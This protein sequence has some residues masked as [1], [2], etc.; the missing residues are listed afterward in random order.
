MLFEFECPWCGQDFKRD[1]KFVNK[2]ILRG[3]KTFCCSFACSRAFLNVGQ[4]EEKVKWVR[5]KAFQKELYR[6]YSSGRYSIR[7]LE[8]YFGV[9]KKL[10]RQILGE[11][12]FTQEE[13]DE[14]G[15]NNQYSGRNI[16][17]L[18]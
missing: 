16:R 17:C 2:A 13:I 3:Q 1:T 18:R 9:G 11:L 8:I 4:D 12:G 7:N 15:A 6:L 10:L 5:S 14:V